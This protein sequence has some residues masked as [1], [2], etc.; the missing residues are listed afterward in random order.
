MFVG[1]LVNYMGKRW[2][3]EAHQFHL[4]PVPVRKY[5]DLNYILGGGFKSPVL[6]STQFLGIWSIWT[7][8]FFK[9]G[10]FHH[11]LVLFRC[12]DYRRKQAFPIKIPTSKSIVLKRVPGSM[13]FY[14]NTWNLWMTSVYQ[15][16]KPLLYPIG[17]MYGMSRYCRC[18][19]ESTIHR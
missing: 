3:N 9:W 18:L 10:W 13:S 8:I 5:G 4:L 16:V 2:L 19:Q 14:K 12:K 15:R 6:F 11:Q 7:S 1:P 17:S